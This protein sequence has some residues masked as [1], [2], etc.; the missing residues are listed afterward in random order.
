MLLLYVHMDGWKRTLWQYQC[1]WVFCGF[2]YQF[3]SAYG[4]SV[5]S[6]INFFISMDG[7]VQIKCQFFFNW[8]LEDV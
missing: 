2:L 4:F 8:H 3:F 6:C 1:M 5:D 7:D